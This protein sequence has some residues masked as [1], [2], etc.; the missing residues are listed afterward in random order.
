MTIWQTFR[1]LLADRRG[2]IATGLFGLG[3]AAVYFLIEGPAASL[4]YYEYQAI[5]RT[6][7]LIL[8][9]FYI[10]PLTRILMRGRIPM[11]EPRI[12]MWIALAVTVNVLS[13]ALSSLLTILIYILAPDALLLLPPEWHQPV[14]ETFVLVPLLGLFVW[15]TGLIS[16]N[17]PRKSN[18]FDSIEHPANLR[19]G[20][21]YYTC[22]QYIKIAGLKYDFKISA[23]HK[24]LDIPNMRSHMMKTPA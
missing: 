3:S 7:G 4:G 16:A 18:G 10:F 19:N 23:Y 14:I 2:W 5:S 17:V 22:T 1:G 8:S 6:A 24:S 15:E 11:G 12:Y 20:T 13:F 21:L 9:A